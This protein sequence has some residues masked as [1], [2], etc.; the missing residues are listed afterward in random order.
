MYRLKRQLHSANRGRDVS[1]GHAL[2]RV[3]ENDGC[4]SGRG[5]ATPA[6]EFA[7]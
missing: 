2:K 5:L 1:L 6:A 7:M 4:G 3:Y